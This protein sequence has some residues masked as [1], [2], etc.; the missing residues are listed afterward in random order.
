MADKTKKS[1][2][3]IM[4]S[5]TQLK[6]LIEKGKEHGVLSFSEI[7]EAISDDV[8]SFDQIEDIV[9]QFQEL[10]I[11][12]VDLEK[13]KKKKSSAGAGTVVAGK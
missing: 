8:T 9:V 5:E 10:G 2:E 4:I 13:I 3:N 11:T 7:N 6:I 1:A 12:L